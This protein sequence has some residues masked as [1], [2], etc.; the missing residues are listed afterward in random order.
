[1]AART[2]V[3]VDT[4]DPNPCAPSV[5]GVVRCCV[6]EHEDGGGSGSGSSGSGSG[7]SGSGGSGETEDEM[8]CEQ[9]TADHCMQLGGIPK[10]GGS[11]D[12]NPCTTSPGCA[13]S[14]HTARG[15]RLGRG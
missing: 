12:P 7:G 11:C 5:P 1:C 9:L 6:P 10:D 8:E 2:G 3:K 14:R 4:C 13:S 15:G